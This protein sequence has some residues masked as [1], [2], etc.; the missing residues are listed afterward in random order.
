[1]K[2]SGFHIAILLVLIAMAIVLGG[3]AYALYQWAR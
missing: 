1:M 2:L 3:L